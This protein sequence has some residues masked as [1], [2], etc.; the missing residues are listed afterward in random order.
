MHTPQRILVVDLCQSSRIPNIA[1]GYL[2]AGLR[3][4]GF[5]V[6]VFSPLSVGARGFSRE[7]IDTPLSHLKRRIH[8]SSHP[9]MLRVHDTLH[10][11]WKYYNR[12]RPLPQ[13][14]QSFRETLR[15]QSPDLVMISAYLDHYPTVRLMAEETRA[16][17]VPLLLGGPAFNSL[18]TIKAWRD[19]PGLTAIVGQEIEFSIA[20]IARSA[21]EGTGLDQ[22]PGVHSPNG[23]SG[24]PAFP[25]PDLSKLPVPDYQDFP[26]EKYEHRILPVMTGRGCQWGKC[27]FCSDVKSVNGIGRFRSRGL[28]GVL[29]E[30][31]T[32]GERHEANSTFFVDIK[33]NS[34]LDMWRGLINEYQNCLPGGEWVGVVH[35]DRRTDNGLS[36]SDLSAAREAGMVRIS[37]GLESGS[38]RL[39]DRMAKGTTVQHLGEF[40]QDARKAGIS[41]R[42]TMMLG[43]PGEQA[44]DIHSTLDFLDTYGSDVDRINLSRFALFPGTELAQQ[45]ERKPE[46]HTGLTLLTW[47]HRNAQVR[48]R[49]EPSMTR[50]YRKA[51]SQLLK[52]VHEVNSRPLP[53]EAE[54]FNGVM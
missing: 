26:W 33:L 52:A 22:H 35:V 43:F 1:V 38:Q 41:T 45:L 10:S 11:M 6:S 30:L 2:V 39:N 51:K 47:D 27:V 28:E 13:V 40:F 15:D 42:A 49:Y 18:E 54:I 19:L 36:L 24:P 12:G 9:A 23:T 20:D 50:E 48:Y 17:N 8:F 3:E 29:H 4:N 14:L 34:D 31:R 44:E 25:I 21:I 32:L 7:T 5:D 16:A 37:C 46:M 53:T